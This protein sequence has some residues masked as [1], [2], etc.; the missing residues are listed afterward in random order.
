LNLNFKLY[1]KYILLHTNQLFLKYF[2]KN[3][4]NTNIILLQHNF[5]YLSMHIKLSSIFYSTQLVDMFAYEL[6]LNSN[7][8]SSSFLNLPLLNNSIIVYNFHSIFYQQRFFIFVLNYSH[9]NINKNSLHWNSLFSITEL[10]CNANWLEREVAE[11]HGVFFCGKKDLR[12]LLLQYGDTSAPMMKSY[13]SIG[14]REIF[15]DSI[16]DLWI[17]NPVTIQF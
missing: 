4:K 1:F 13:P 8:P 3:D 14:T 15:Y 17:Q 11:L 6:P 10:F 2:F 16:S 5:Y 9:Q 7:T 12:N